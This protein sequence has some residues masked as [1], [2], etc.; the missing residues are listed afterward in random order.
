[1]SET[2]SN[3]RPIR[4]P[5][6]SPRVAARPAN[7]IQP[8]RFL[9]VIPARGGSKG[10]PGKNLLRVAGRSLVARAVDVARSVEAIGEVVVSSDSSRILDEVIRAGARALR[11]PPALATDE[12][13]TI[14]VVRHV[15]DH[16]PGA[17]VVVILQPTSPL[18]IP[19]DVEA[20]LRVFDGRHSVVT[21][22][23][24]DHPVEWTMRIDEDGRLEPVWGW[25]VPTRR[26]DCEERYRLN[27]AVYV[28]PAD[29]VRRGGPVVGPG[30]KAVVMPPERSVDI[31]SALD[32]QLARL[33]AG[34]TDRPPG[35]IQA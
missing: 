33:L 31:D 35:T 32:L 5:G 1:M 4:A 19:A 30:T 14:D 13:T 10:L 2:S 24:L 17:E 28:V 34:A 11:R 18:R 25:D 7:P 16:Y 27:G 12:A 23:L 9:A 8:H 6:R 3:R 21:V 29:T 22:T 15:V 26:Q 20:C